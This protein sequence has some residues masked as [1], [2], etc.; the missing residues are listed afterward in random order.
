[1]VRRAA[2]APAM[3]KWANTSNKK[4]M[5]A[6][7]RRIPVEGKQRSTQAPPDL[8][9]KTSSSDNHFCPNTKR[10]ES[11]GFGSSTDIGCAPVR[12]CLE[13]FPGMTQKFL[14]TFVVSAPDHKWF[15]G[16]PP[17]SL[18]RVDAFQIWAN[19]R[20]NAARGLTD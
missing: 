7:Q 8:D 16:R 15:D 3:Q 5:S 1:M 19:L 18:S 10:L 4:D 2:P 9:R 12:I 17:R 14:T 6:A 11:D 13:I 20:S